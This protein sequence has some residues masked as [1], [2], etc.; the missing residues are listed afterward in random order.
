MSLEQD[1]REK[2]M[3]LR[4]EEGGERESG[5]R[6]CFESSEAERERDAV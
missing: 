1:F 5:F 4:E 3:R 2:R 6:D